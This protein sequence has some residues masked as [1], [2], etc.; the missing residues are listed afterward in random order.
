MADR[1]P[2]FPIRGQM[3]GPRAA[4]RGDLDRTG[5][6][7][8]RRPPE[9]VAKPLLQR[10]SGVQLGRLRQGDR[11]FLF[12]SNVLHHARGLPD[13]P[14]SMAADPLAALADPTLSSRMP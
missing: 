4:W 13:L 5:A 8:D 3:A 14:H 1:R 12:D 6:G 9:P 10:A 7:R 2:L 11:L